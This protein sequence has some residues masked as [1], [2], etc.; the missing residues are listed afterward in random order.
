MSILILDKE[1]EK[2]KHI[3][4]KSEKNNFPQA[5]ILY[6]YL[7]SQHKKVSLYGDEKESK[8][9]FLAWHDKVRCKRPASADFEI[10]A[11][12]EIKAL[13]TF[14]QESNIKI[15]KKM[16]TAFYAGFMQRYNN[17]MSR[18][19]NGT[20]FAILSELIEYG[21]DHN[22]C[23]SEMIERV[24]LSS[25]RLKSILYKKLLLKKNATIVEVKLTDMDFVQS[26]AQWED[27]LSLSNELLNLVHVQEVQIIK[28]DEKDKILK[29]VKEV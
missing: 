28:S 5:S 27:L 21:A 20:I 14:I 17:F 10:D 24:P 8:F 7:L 26:G 16:A 12:I 25:I 3:L 19:C 2:S 13:Y 18:D 29:I 1:I 4:I 15:N 6:S 22:Y 11:S 23:I 9:S